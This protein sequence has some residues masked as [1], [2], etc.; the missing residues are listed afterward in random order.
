MT[1]RIAAIAVALAALAPATAQAVLHVESG[2][3]FVW[4]ELGRSS[5]APP[6]YGGG[7]VAMGGVDPSTDLAGLFLPGDQLRITRIAIGGDASFDSGVARFALA[8]DPAG[9]AFSWLAGQASTVGLVP[10]TTYNLGFTPG[11]SLA[12]GFVYGSLNVLLAADA[13]F[14][15]TWTDQR[16]FDSKYLLGTDIYGHAFSDPSSSVRPWVEF[17]IVSNHVP[18]PAG[19]AVLGMGLLGLALRRRRAT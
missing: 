11:S 13:G 10:S 9:I 1:P 16:D 5:N 15:V 2:G 12:Q 17:E 19:M 8:S 7:P 14:A 3:K 4:T 6:P 18:E